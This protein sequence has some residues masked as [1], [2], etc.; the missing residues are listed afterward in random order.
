MGISA[1][2]REDRIPAPALPRL[3]LGRAAPATPADRPGRKRI[4]LA[5]QGG[6]AHG[7]FTWGVL[8]RLLQEPDLE[9]V[10]ISGT[11]A[12]AMNAVVT[13]DG[14]ARGG[15]H[16]A[17]DALEAFWREVADAARRS[18]L[19]PTTLERTLGLAETRLY[20]GRLWLEGLSRVASPYTLNPNGHNPLRDVLE[21]SVDFD[22]LR[23]EPPVHLFVCATEVRGGKARVFGPE[24]ISVEAVLASAC[25]PTL[26]HPVEID[27]ETYWD[28]GYLSNPPL[29]PLVEGTDCD[30]ILIVQVDPLRLA[31]A[32]TTAEDIRDRVQT[33][34]F[35]AGFVTEMHALATLGR[36]APTTPPPGTGRWG[37][38][39]RRLLDLLG[40]PEPRPVRMHLVEAETEMA[41]LKPATK[42][43]PDEAFLERLFE[44]GR[45]RAEGF[46]D[47]HK[48]AIGVRS[49]LDVAGRFL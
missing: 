37:Q 14:L 9:I 38:L 20:A 45:E 16:G 2:A 11:S 30:D 42:L 40:R 23:R 13:A 19:T 17:R 29:L 48:G 15:S 36:I 22:R 8:D 39:S 3:R 32:P 49:S 47:E 46:L 5:L 26:F 1:L 4:N 34:G 28:G 10:G 31:E 33:L 18:G 27:G 41:G 25:L 35:N 21:A 6:G 44:L 7:A 43:D 12:G 24:E